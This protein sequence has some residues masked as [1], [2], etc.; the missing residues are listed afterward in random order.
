[1]PLEIHPLFWLGANEPEENF[2]TLAVPFRRVMDPCVTLKYEPSE[3]TVDR[4]VKRMLK[5]N[6]ETLLALS[7][8]L[9]WRWPRGW[10]AI[11][12][13]HLAEAT[14]MKKKAYWLSDMGRRVSKGTKARARAKAAAKA[15]G[16]PAPPAPCPEISGPGRPPQQQFRCRCEGPGPPRPPKSTI[17]GRSK[18]HIS[19]T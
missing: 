2:T 9:A 19:K 3:R 4:Y 1:M 11:R 17:S 10:A 14:K 6:T 7:L 5:M 18:K 13:K 15:R 16:R 8:E 12:L